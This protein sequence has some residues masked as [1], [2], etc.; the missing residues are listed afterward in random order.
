MSSGKLFRTILP[1]LLLIAVSLPVLAQE[2]DEEDEEY[3]TE[4]VTTATI[5]ITSGYNSRVFDK[6]S[7]A[8]W[9][10]LPVD[11]TPGLREAVASAVGCPAALFQSAAPDLRSTRVIADP[12]RRARYEKRLV[13]DA[14]RRLNATCPVQHDR[15]VYRMRVDVAPLL[16]YLRQAE[17]KSV[18]VWI[19]HPKMPYAAQTEQFLSPGMLAARGSLWYTIPVTDATP[20]AIWTEYGYSRRELA[21][22]G[23][24]LAAIILLPLAFILW[25]RSRALRLGATDRTAAWFSYFRA[26]NWCVNGAFL[27]WMVSGSHARQMLMGALE[28]LW[29]PGGNGRMAL[30]LCFAFLPPWALYFVTLAASYE[31]L[32]QIRGI[33]WK[34]SEYLLTQFVTV[35]TVMLPLMCFV[36][37]LDNLT[38]SSTVAAGVLFVGVAALLICARLK[39]KLTKQHPEALTTGEMRDRIFEIARKAGVKVKQIFIMPAGKM[40]LANAFA[41]QNQIVMFTDYAL[42]KLNKREVDAV[43]AHELSHLQFKHPMKLG[44]TI[45]FVMLLPTLGPIFLGASSGLVLGLLMLATKNY[46]L[47]GRF[48][49]LAESGGFDSPLTQTAI[50]GIGLLLFFG[51]SRRFERQADRRA[52]E[53]TNDPE[54]LITALFKLSLVNLTPLQWGKATGVFLTHPS[55]LK[56]AE[57]IADAGLVPPERLQQIVS[58]F[59]SG[60][61]DDPADHYIPP[62]EAEQRVVTTTEQLQRSQT[63]LLWLLLGHVVPATAFAFVAQQTIWGRHHALNMY[64]VGAIFAVLF[65]A[66][67]TRGLGLRGRAKMRAKFETKFRREGLLIDYAQSRLVGFSP[68]PWPRFYVSS[69]NWDNGML[70]RMRDGLL[71]VGDQVRFRLTPQMVQEVW[72]GPGSPSVWRTPRVY[73]RWADESTGRRGVFSLFPMDPAN[74]ISIEHKVRALH[75]EIMQWWKEQSSFAACPVDLAKLESPSIGE[76]TSQSPK[77]IHTAKKEFTFIWLMAILSWGINSVTGARAFL[78]IFSVTLL[79]RLYEFIPYML[80]KDRAVPAEWSTPMP[81]AQKVMAAGTGESSASE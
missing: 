71:Y 73:I 44:L 43:A 80:Y 67:L 40:Q 46:T 56:R 66:F 45:I 23:G 27:L 81:P 77:T 16:P 70:V 58:Q 29:G 60:V 76:V 62:V 10:P 50:M 41:A 75:G 4:S 59:Q 31:V 42:Q 20:P 79:L 49:Q 37:T 34:R 36:A 65:Y 48:T 33:Q 7:V 69:Y 8:Y 12:E 14:A 22:S 61:T 38:R 63:A 13:E 24:L 17:V 78:Y 26:Q 32:V 39:A 1:F 57:R 15:L 74:V 25:T 35:A 3:G 2:Y 47:L 5:S 30:S 28:M 52:V 51:M 53:L 54:A 64:G 21:I 9:G 19:N 11:Q 6:V 55:T 18:L 72:L 68:G